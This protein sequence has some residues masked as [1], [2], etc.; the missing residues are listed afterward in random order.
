LIPVPLVSFLDGG[1]GQGG[2]L[3]SKLGVGAFDVRQG[4]FVGGEA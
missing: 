2:E 4:V 3:A 1:G